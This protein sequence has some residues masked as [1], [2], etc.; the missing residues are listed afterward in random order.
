MLKGNRKNP[1]VNHTFDSILGEGAVMDEG[2]VIIGRI[3][4]LNNQKTKLV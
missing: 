2:A 4:P 3:I 1:L